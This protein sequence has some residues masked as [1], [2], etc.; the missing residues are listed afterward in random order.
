MKAAKIRRMLRL[1]QGYLGSN[2]PGEKMVSTKLDVARCEGRIDPKDAYCP[3]DDIPPLGDGCEITREGGLGLWIRN[4]AGKI[5][6]P[7]KRRTEILRTTR[8]HT[9][10]RARRPRLLRTTASGLKCSPIPWPLPR[11]A[12][13]RGDVCGR[14]AAVDEKAGAGDE[15]RRIRREEERCLGDLLRQTEPAHR[16]VD[17]PPPPLLLGVQELH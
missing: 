16:Y 10:G 15:R 7:R 17:E 4:R 9:T 11:C 5:G 14:D 3:I 12:L 2:V 8:E 6:S 1:T 13:L